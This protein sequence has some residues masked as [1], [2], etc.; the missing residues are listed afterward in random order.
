KLDTLSGQMT[1]LVRIWQSGTTNSG[2]T[3]NTPVQ[4]TENNTSNE[5]VEETPD[6]NDAY[7]K[8]QL[9]LVATELINLANSDT[10]KNAMSE[11][12]TSSISVKGTVSNVNMTSVSKAFKEI[13]KL[14][15]NNRYITKTFFGT[16]E[17]NFVSAPELE[18]PKTYTP[19]SEQWYKLAQTGKDVQCSQI[20]QDEFTKEYVVTLS[21][22]VKKND[23]E[24]GVLGAQINL[25]KIK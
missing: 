16:K 18:V 23:R 11:L 22:M 1:E 24:V 15:D 13:S 17:E 4:G 5:K 9:G 10:I 19:T 25:S 7:I 3:G 6:I 21:I 8:E 20:H 2:N 12:D 14:K